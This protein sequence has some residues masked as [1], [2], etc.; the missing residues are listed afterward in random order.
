MPR[1]EDEE[2]EEETAEKDSDAAAGGGGEDLSDLLSQMDR[3]QF[4]IEGEL[5]Q[6]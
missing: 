2:T 4:D 6:M 3:I 1:E 5:K